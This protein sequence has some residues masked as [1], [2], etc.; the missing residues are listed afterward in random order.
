MNGFRCRV[1]GATGTKGIGKPALARRCGADP[2]NGR[3]NAT[4]SNCTVGPKQPF[5]WDQAERN[6]VRID[7][8]G[9]QALLV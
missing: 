4:P 5:Y 8:T 3:P 1:S 2:D 6:N 9:L 7:S